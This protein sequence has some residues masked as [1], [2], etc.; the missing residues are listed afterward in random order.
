MLDLSRRSRFKLVGCEILA[1]G[2]GRLG[3]RTLL[4]DRGFK[5]GIVRDMP[6][7]ARDGLAG[8]IIEVYPEW[9]RAILLT[10]PASAVS[11]RDQ[12]SRVTGIV[13]WMPEATSRL[14]L[15]G[16]SYL[17]DVAVDDSLISSG[18]GGVFPAGLP[19]GTIAEIERDENGL[20]LDITVNAA[21]D[22]NR[23]EEVF[24]LVEDGGSLVEDTVSAV[25]EGPSH[26]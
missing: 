6:I 10:H 22:F 12:R 26:P 5:H 19:V 2:G 17:A 15:R 14:K 1:E 3:D 23:L 16:V 4:L 8:K 13:E 18:L 7:T 11:V 20:L 9:S 21:A 25:G 24:A